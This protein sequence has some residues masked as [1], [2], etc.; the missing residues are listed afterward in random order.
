MLLKSVP[1]L[2]NFSGAVAPK[3]LECCIGL[4]VSDLLGTIESHL[5][6]VVLKRD[7]ALLVMRSHAGLNVVHQGLWNDELFLDESPVKKLV[8]FAEFRLDPLVDRALRHLADEVL[9]EIDE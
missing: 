4:A 1:Y 2:Q 8:D 3:P 5:A 6:Q 7:D 9:V